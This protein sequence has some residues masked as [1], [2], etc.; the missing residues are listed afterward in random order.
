VI[1][2]I[3][4]AYLVAL[5]AIGA[6][7]TRRT[8][9]ARDFFVAGSGIGLVTLSVSA[10]AATLSGFA[11]IGG[12]G[13][14]YRAGLGAAFIVF[15]SAITNTLSAWVMAKRLR[16]LA[17]VRDVVTIPDAIRIRYDSPLAQ[18][19]AAVAI[20]SAVIGYIGT[21]L[22]ALGLV[23]DPIFGTGLRPAILIGSAVVLAYSVSGG[24]LAG[25]YNDV[26]QGLIMA[27]ASVL[28]FLRALDVTGG[29]SGLSRTL[30]TVAP[31]HLAPWGTLTPLAAMSYFF[32]FGMGTLG[33]PHVLHKFY[34][35][36]DPLKLRWFPVGMTLAMT[37]TLL[38]FVGVGLAMKALVATG[39]TP[40]LTNPDDA[41][42]TFLLRFAP[43]PLAGLVFTAAAAAI[44]ST[45]NSFLSVGA[46]ALTR[47]LPRAIGRPVADE[48][49]WG[50]RWTVALMLLAT[51]VAVQ[52]G[53]VVAFLG[54]FGWGLFASTLV[55]A[56]TVGL[57]WE[58]ATRAGAV[59]SIA[60]G[61]VATLLLETLAWLKW[62]TLPAGVTATAVTLV[63]SLLVFFAVSRLTRERQTP[64][65]ADLVAVLRA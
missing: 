44:M 49:R 26:L 40:P 5:L 54:I 10:M 58:G 36:R 34:M 62:F 42:P 55:P 9:T 23:I 19:L 1:I 24:I 51:I 21:N 30:M 41:T 59:A 16:L 6:W 43:E 53:V 56:L 25:I 32:V 50:R 60:T 29:L 18:G 38:L 2:G 45:V 27:V 14:I 46:A 12:P 17:E 11:F 13:F 48:L 28:V 33:Q 3:A 7:A 57:N 37:L 20:I 52:P 15:P 63:G 4:V 31:E 22:L 61:L 39:T 35:L 65:A 47:D 8:H 64:L